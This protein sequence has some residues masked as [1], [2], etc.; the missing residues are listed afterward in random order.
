MRPSLQQHLLLLEDLQPPKANLQENQG[1][2]MGFPG[3][4][5][6]GLIP[7]RI[8]DLLCSPL[9]LPWLLGTAGAS[10]WIPQRFLGA[11]TVGLRGAGPHSTEKGQKNPSALEGTSWESCKN[12]L[13]KSFP[14]TESSREASPKNSCIPHTWGVLP[15]FFP[16]SFTST[17]AGK[18]ESLPSCKVRAKPPSFLISQFGNRERKMCGHTQRGSWKKPRY[19]F[20]RWKT[21]GHPWISQPWSKHLP[22]AGIF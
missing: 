19:H 5:T 8:L 3:C 6:A 4:E 15:T 21:G 17:F 16:A 7:P 9:S 12:P 11:G 10:S 2:S 22:L 1:L 18:S 14:L 20:Q 13:T